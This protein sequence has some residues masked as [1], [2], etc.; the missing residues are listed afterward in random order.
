MRFAHV[1]SY[2]NLFDNI[3]SQGI[4]SRSYAQ[5]LIEG[6][7]FSNATQPVSTYG[8]VIPDDSPINPTG[9]FEPDGFANLGAT[10]DFGTGKNNITAI[11]T[12]TSVPYTYTLT[13]LADVRSIVT[14]GA[15]IGK[16]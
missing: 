15:G 9:D 11:G 3:V 14:A 12:F 8:F 6:N 4:H 7:V 10:N 5:V 1:H 2:N 16:I 13:P